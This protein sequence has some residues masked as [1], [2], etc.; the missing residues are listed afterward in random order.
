MARFSHR[1]EACATKILRIINV[2]IHHYDQ[3]GGQNALGTIEKQ[4]I[5][6][7]P[8]PLVA[9]VFNLCIMSLF[10]RARGILPGQQLMPL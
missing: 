9:Q 3:F 1:L 6:K 10:H 5:P 4:G 2:V 7:R 8:E